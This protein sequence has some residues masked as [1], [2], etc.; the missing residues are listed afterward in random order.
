[1]EDLY[2]HVHWL[3]LYDK[4]NRTKEELYEMWDRDPHWFPRAFKTHEAPGKLPFD[5]KVKYGAME[6]RGAVYTSEKTPTM[7]NVRSTAPA[8]RQIHH[9]NSSTKVVS[10]PKSPSTLARIPPYEHSNLHTN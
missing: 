1:M 3:E 7:L 6:H 2:E 9:T 5:D 8:Y 10:T 4:P